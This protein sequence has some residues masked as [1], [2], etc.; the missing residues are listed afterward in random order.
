[1]SQIKMNPLQPLVVSR[2]LF[3]SSAVHYIGCR[4]H[5]RLFSKIPDEFKIDLVVAHV[6]A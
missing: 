6:I 1:M 2:S 5:T 3:K 4:S